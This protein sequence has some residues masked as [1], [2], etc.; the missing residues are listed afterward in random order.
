MMLVVTA[1]LTV[2]QRQS[3]GAD[4]RSGG[5]SHDLSAGGQ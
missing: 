5:S 4:A 3:A 2:E 1:P